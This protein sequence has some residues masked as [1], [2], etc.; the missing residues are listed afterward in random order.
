[1]LEVTKQVKWLLDRKPNRGSG[2][3]F[4]FGLCRL[5]RAFG[6]SSGGTIQ[7]MML[8]YGQCADEFRQENLKAL[9][10]AA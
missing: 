8:T 5:M 4:W 10:P 7:T 6:R 2:L 3:E 9:S 1:M